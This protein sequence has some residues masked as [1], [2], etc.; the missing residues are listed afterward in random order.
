MWLRALA[1]STDGLIAR[2]LLRGVIAA[3]EV[4]QVAQGF[5]AFAFERRVAFGECGAVLS[6]AIATAPPQHRR[7][8][9]TSAEKACLLRKLVGLSGLPSVARSPADLIAVSR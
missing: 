7:H 9:K 6:S 2:Q 5:V 1:L 3:E 8:S 4:A